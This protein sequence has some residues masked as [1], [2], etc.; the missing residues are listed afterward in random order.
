MGNHNE[1]QENSRMMQ[2]ASRYTVLTGLV[3]ES[4]RRRRALRADAGQDYASRETASQL[5]MAMDC[6]KEMSFSTAC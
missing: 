2:G 5:T 3:R 6:A 4:A 1:V